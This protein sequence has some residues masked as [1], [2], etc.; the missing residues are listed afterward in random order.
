ML[1]SI[2][3]IKNITTPDK[4]LFLHLLESDLLA[5]SNEIRELEARAKAE[6]A[7]KDALSE[8]ETWGLTRQ[9]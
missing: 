4:L 3:K 8:L 6:I 9:F 7:I 5:K 1:F 2:L